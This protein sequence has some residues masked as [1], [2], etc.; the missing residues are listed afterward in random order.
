LTPE[1]E[2]LLK[3]GKP[4]KNSKER[5]ALL[6]QAFREAGFQPP[7]LPGPDLSAPGASENPVDAE[8]MAHHLE[9]GLLREVFARE[10]DTPEFK[11]VAAELVRS[12]RE[13]DLLQTRNFGEL[14]G[15]AQ[16]TAKVKR[17]A[18]LRKA[19]AS[20]LTVDVRPL[21]LNNLKQIALAFHNY[22]D[23]Y[24]TFPAAVQTGPKQVPRSWRVTILPF[25]E[26]LP[27]YQKYRQ[28]EPWDSAHNK[29]LLAEIPEVFR[30]PRAPANS[31]NTAYSGFSPPDDSASPAKVLQFAPA[32]GG[33]RGINMAQITDGTSNTL[34]VVEA[35]LEVPWTK[36]ED[37]PFDESRPVPFLGGIHQAGF[38]AALC[39]GSAGFI[40]D[41][42]DRDMLKRLIGRSDGQQPKPPW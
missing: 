4:A 6:Q 30:S 19:A 40:P 1:N 24:K 35:N 15:R 23:V 9:V 27:L 14:A 29:A 41:A 39:D 42:Y 21:S 17:N 32:L 10:G 34:L 20:D 7:R 13:D 28:D 38:C 31:T 25:L 36:P 18:D 26:N 5:L 8:L 33:T 16:Q 2:G 37:I 11:Y 12:L 3:S 22:H